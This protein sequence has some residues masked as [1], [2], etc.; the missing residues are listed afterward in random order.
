MASF[1]TKDSQEAIDFSR[2]AVDHPLVD[3]NDVATLKT[4]ILAAGLSVAELVSTAWASAATFRGSDKRGGA[5]GARVRLAPQMYWA[6]NQ[7]AQLSK[8]IAALEGVQ[9]EF[10]D[11]QSGGK[12]ISIADLIV[13]GGCAAIEKAAQN[14]GHNIN[15]PFTAAAL[16]FPLRHPAV[17]TVLSGS[18][19]VSELKQNLESFNF[20]LPADLWSQMESAGLIEPLN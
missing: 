4:K 17:A 7:P 11:N 3:D 18:A 10:N 13:L 12:K 8:V 2:P 16:Q 6:V 1:M 9:K 20:D 14:A 19:K 15:V 5:N